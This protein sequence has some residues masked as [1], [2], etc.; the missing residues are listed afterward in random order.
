MKL[1]FAL[2]RS[3]NPYEAGVQRITYNLGKYFIAKGIDVSFYSLRSN[4]ENTYEFTSAYAFP[5][6]GDFSNSNN[7]THF[8]STIDHLRPDIIINQMPYENELLGLLEKNKTKYGFKVISCIHNTLF[9]F[10]NNIK[11]IVLRKF[12]KVLH[13]IVASRLFIFLLE[14]IHIK[15]HIAHLQRVFALSDQLVLYTQA[16]LDELHFFIGNTYDAKIEIIG[17]PVLLP[18]MNFQLKEQLILHVGRLSVAQKRSDLLLEFWAKAHKLLPN[19]RFVIV[20][21]GNY[22]QQLKSKIERERLP[23]VELTGRQVPDT[24]YERASIFIIP[25]EFEGLPNTILEAQSYGCPVLAFDS[26]AALKQI[27]QD[28]Q[29][30]LLSPPFHVDHMVENAIKLCQSTEMLNYFQ[31]QSLENANRFHIDVIGKKWMELFK[32]FNK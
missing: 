21:D 7:I 29:N 22:F 1:L 14:K 13:P 11:S 16:N 9:S 25:S 19:W 26:Y 32:M 28:G 8:L 3:I 30:A 18:S 4:I 5:E 27:V 2:T 17:N 24:Y 15:K 23:R 10:K 12:P 6:P 20:G 31:Q